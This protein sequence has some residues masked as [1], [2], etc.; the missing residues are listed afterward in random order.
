MITTTR[1]LVRARLSEGASHHGRHDDGVNGPHRKKVRA[2]ERILE[3]HDVGE[4]R[5]V[6]A[7]AKGVRAV[8]EYQRRVRCASQQERKVWGLP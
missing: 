4:A 8:G 5:E 1:S 6:D 3:A 7:H 2:P